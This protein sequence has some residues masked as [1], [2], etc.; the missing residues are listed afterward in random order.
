MTESFKKG[1]KPGPGRPKGMPNK[2]TL[3]AKTAIATAAQELGGADRLVAWAKEDPVNERAFW[4][5]VYP[6]LIPAQ[7]EHSGPDG[8]DLRVVYE[9][10]KP[11]E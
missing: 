5:S 8:S 2:T 7:L 10:A 3:I 4:V 6:K 11:S 1:G 9:W